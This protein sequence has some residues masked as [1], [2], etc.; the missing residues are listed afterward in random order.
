MRVDSLG[1]RLEDATVIEPYSAKHLEDLTN[2]ESHLV[3]RK[4][5]LRGDVSVHHTR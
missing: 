2:V 1:S 5:S 3:E 4:E